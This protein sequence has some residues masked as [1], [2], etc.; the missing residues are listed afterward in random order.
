MKTMKQIFEPYHDFISTVYKVEREL[1][2][3][4]DIITSIKSLEAF[5]LYEENGGRSALWLFVRD[6]M[7]DIRAHFDLE[8]IAMNEKKAIALKPKVEKYRKLYH[9]TSRGLTTFHK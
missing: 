4:I 3:S 8:E 1:I 5:E 6:I 9:D 7:N 2:T